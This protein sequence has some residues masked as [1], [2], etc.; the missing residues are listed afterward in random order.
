MKWKCSR[1]AR[2]CWSSQA[3]VTGCA[4]GL[5]HRNCVKLLDWFESKGALKLCILTLADAE[6][7]QSIST[8]SSRCVSIPFGKRSRSSNDA[9]I[10]EGGELFDRMCAY[11]CLFVMA[12]LEQRTA[13]RR[14]SLPNTMPSSPFERRSRVS[15]TFTARTSFIAT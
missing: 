12:L 4:Q 9:Q 7:A 8:W 1:C 14:A 3:G 13:T 5:D 15:P 2:I 10:A 6:S 11:L